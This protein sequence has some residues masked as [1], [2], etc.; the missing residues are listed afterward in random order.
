VKPASLQHQLKP[1]PIRVGSTATEGHDCGA[2]TMSEVAAEI[3]TE[4]QSTIRR[5]AFSAGPRPALLVASP[6]ASVNSLA[7]EDA[8]DNAGDA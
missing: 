6:S 2:R 3:T 8:E 1:A 4:V 7:A 5:R